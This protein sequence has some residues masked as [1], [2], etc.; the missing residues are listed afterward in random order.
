MGMAEAIVGA[1]RHT[2][3]TSA[4]DDSA[5][6]Q[7][8]LRLEAVFA[9]WG[10]SLWGWLEH[11]GV[12]T[13]SRPFVALPNEHV[14][15]HMRGLTLLGDAAHVMS[16]FSGARAKI[17]LL[18]GA[19]LGTALA[20]A[21]PGEWDTAVRAQEDRQQARAAHCRKPGHVHQQGASSSTKPAANAY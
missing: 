21:V 14:W 5:R 7:V 19:E 4:A 3:G 17:A 8:V 18:D 12:L 9:D 1:D 15:L 16:P 20:D 11:A 10:P 6:E 13:F 2:P